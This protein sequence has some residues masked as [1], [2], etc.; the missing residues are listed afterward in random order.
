MKMM[1]QAPKMKEVKIGSKRRLL[2]GSAPR[3]L[4]IYDE[5]TEEQI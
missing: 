3:N 1:Y 5:E 2:V 4:S